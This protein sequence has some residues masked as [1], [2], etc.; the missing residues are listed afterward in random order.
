MA[1]SSDETDGRKSSGRTIPEAAGN[2]SGEWC[3]Q[4]GVF[5]ATVS[6]P[7]T[8]KGAAYP[9]GYDPYSSA[10]AVKSVHKLKAP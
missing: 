8:A 3:I 5:G 6:N 4:T 7:G 9:H 10:D 1:G 2:A